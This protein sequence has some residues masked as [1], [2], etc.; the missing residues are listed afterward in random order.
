MALRV[1]RIFCSICFGVK[2]RFSAALAALSALFW[3]WVATEFLARALS[4]DLFK[5][6][7]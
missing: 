6:W 2:S 3:A 1:S 5:A 7:E 4:R